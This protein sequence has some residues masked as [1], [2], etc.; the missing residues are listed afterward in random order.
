MK[1]N[2]RN[3]PFYSRTNDKSY[4]SLFKTWRITSNHIMFIYKQ[5]SQTISPDAYICSSSHNLD[6]PSFQP[7]LCVFSI[8]NSHSFYRSKLKDSVFLIKDLPFNWPALN[9]QAAKTGNKGEGIS[10]FKSACQ[11][12]LLKKGWD[13]ISSNPCEPNLC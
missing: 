3:K 11:S 7:E 13:F 10:F 6:T 9:G 8:L 12:I 2:F 1:K 4:W 5:P